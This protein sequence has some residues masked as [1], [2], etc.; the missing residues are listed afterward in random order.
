MTQNL[1]DLLE[2]EVEIDIG[3]IGRR[4]LMEIKPNKLMRGGVLKTH[5]TLRH[6][7]G[8]LMFATSNFFHMKRVHRE[9]EGKRKIRGDAHKKI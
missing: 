2:R 6:T 7:R 4:S 1:P 3:N 9:H 5:S 8:N